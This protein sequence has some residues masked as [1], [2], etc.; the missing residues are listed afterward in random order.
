M[1]LEHSFLIVILT[2]LF[3][4]FIFYIFDESS[5]HLR[6]I[7]TSRPNGVRSNLYDCKP[8]FTVVELKH[9]TTAQIMGV[10]RK[11]V[12][13]YYPPQINIP[14]FSRINPVPHQYSSPS[15]MTTYAR[16]F[17]CCLLQVAQ[18]EEF[19]KNISAFEYYFTNYF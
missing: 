18:H 12:L 7:I 17:C 19:I 8:S 13:I 16:C 6:I 4:N 14:Q 1:A 15:I 10:L 11:Q 5:L 3:F 9:L 2:C